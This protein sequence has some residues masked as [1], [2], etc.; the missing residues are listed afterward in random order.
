[1]K[2][3]ILDTEHITPRSS[4]L[5]ERMMRLT[6]MSP[7]RVARTCLDAHDRGRLYVLPQLDAKALWRSKRMNPGA[8]TRAAGLLGR[9]TPN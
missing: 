6:G 9:V 3:N 1:V 2:T 4:D 8:F 5:A 7:E